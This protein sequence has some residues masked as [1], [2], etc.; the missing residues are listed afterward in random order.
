MWGKNREK[1][2]NRK[3]SRQKKTPQSPTAMPLLPPQLQQP[4][5]MWGFP[6]LGGPFPLAAAPGTAAGRVGRPSLLEAAAAQMLL[7]QGWGERQAKSK[8]AAKARVRMKPAAASGRRR[9]GWAP[10]RLPK[11]SHGSNEVNDSGDGFFSFRYW[12]GYHRNLTALKELESG[13]GR[14]EQRCGFGVGDI[15]NKEGEEKNKRE[16][17]FKN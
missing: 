16:I 2:G 14:G 17:K 10:W 11:Q 8:W 7:V 6:S 5:G 1:K 4:C 15:V 9:A 3:S 12:S 13:V